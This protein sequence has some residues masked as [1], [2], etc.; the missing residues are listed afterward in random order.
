MNSKMIL[1]VDDEPC[2]RYAF[3][4]IFTAAG[5][6]VQAA[7]S[8]EQALEIMRTSPASVLFIDLN[9]PAMNGLDLCRE[10]RTGWPWS[11]LIAVTGYPSIFE[12]VKC[13]EVGFEDY[14]NKPVDS[15]KLLLAAEQ[16]FQK[17]ERWKQRPKA[18]P[19]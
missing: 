7:E 19:D 17:L 18:L 13:R 16:A 10:L 4:K 12:L 15:K 11:V 5:Y 8:G 9:L 1:V 6:A 2:I 14:F 3:S